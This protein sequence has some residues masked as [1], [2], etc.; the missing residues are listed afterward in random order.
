MG[1]LLFLYKNFTTFFF[2]QC[3]LGVYC[4][5][6]L[7]EQKISL[8]QFSCK[9]EYNFIQNVK[10]RHFCGTKLKIIESVIMDKD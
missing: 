9:E 4:Q 7:T 2:S 3:N 5:G 8:Y 1:C 10:L 6:F